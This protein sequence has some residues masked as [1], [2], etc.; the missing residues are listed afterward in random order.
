MMLSLNVVLSAPSLRITDIEAAKIG[1]AAA[2]R[3]L[4]D[5]EAQLSVYKIIGFCHVFFVLVMA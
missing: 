1:T 4:S 3:D 2:L 5:A